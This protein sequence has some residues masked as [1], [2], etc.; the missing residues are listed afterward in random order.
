MTLVFKTAVKTCCK[1]YLTVLK[2]A[3]R[4]GF[5]TS[6]K[7]VLRALKIS[8][9]NDGPA[10]VFKS[11]YTPWR[12]V[13]E[14]GPKTAMKTCCKHNLTVL[15]R[16]SSLGF[17]TSRKLALRALK[18]RFQNDG[19]V[20]VCKTS[21]TSSRLV[22]KMSLSDICEDVI[23]TVFWPLYQ[24]FEVPT[25]VVLRTTWILVLKGVLNLGSKTSRIL[26]LRTMKMR[27]Q[28]D[29]SV[30]AFKSSYMYWRPVLKTGLQNV[31]KIHLCP[32][33]IGSW[34]MRL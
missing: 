14:I 12:P 19:S 15:K 17:K 11:S 10:N 23:Q 21:Y 6:R 8:L 34:E 1:Q 27:L 29:G 2:R 24:H 4:L 13:F 26:V 20:N 7:L 33:G 5:K 28:N 9:Q 22:F 3:F 31:I 32:L 30:N 25:I 18:I 16:A